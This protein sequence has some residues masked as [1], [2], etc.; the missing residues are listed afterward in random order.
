[1]QPPVDLSRRVG[2]ATGLGASQKGF[3]QF[4]M[5][6]KPPPCFSAGI[7]K[8]IWIVNLRSTK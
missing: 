3:W 2:K 6:A 5:A 8:R 4:K 7:V 1:M